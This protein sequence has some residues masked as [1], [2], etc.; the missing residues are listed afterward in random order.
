MDRYICIHGHFYQPPRE[1]PWLEAIEIQDSAFPYHD[2]NERIAAECYAAN[3]VSRI[4]DTEG[5]IAQLV[6]NYASISFNF[7]PTVL[8]WMQQYATDAYEAILEG[9][10]QS[11]EKFSGHGNALAQAYNHMIMPLANSRDKNTQIIWGI[12]DFQFRFG[13]KPEGLWLPETAV[14]LETL[15]LMAQHGID[16]AILAPSQASRVR[17]IDGTEWQDVSGGR[18]YPAMAYRVSLP[19]GRVMA[20]FFYDGPIAQALAFEGLLDNGEVFAN[21]LLS[22]FAD[23][24][25]RL[26]HIATDGESYGHHHRGG[27]MALAHA[28]HHIESN[29]LAQV[30]NY[31]RYLDHHPPTYEV[32]IFEN[33]SWSCVHGIERWRSDCGCNSGGHSGWN[34]G[35]RAPLRAALDWLR[36]AVNPA[37]ERLAGQFL[38]DPWAAR[39]DYIDII[40]DRSPDRISAFL[41]RHATR[42]L[43]SGDEITVLKLLELQRNAMLMYTSCG[44][45]FD[46]LSGI[47]TVQIIQYAGR[48]LQLADQLFGDSFEPGFLERLELAG[49]NIPEHRDGRTI[50]EK[51]VRPAMLDMKDVG[52]HYAL[53][54][55]F[56]DIGERSSIYAYSATRE[57]YRSFQVGGSRL[58]IG[59]AT[60]T[61]EITRISSSLCFGVLHLG[62]HNIACGTGEYHGAQ[63]YEAL[64]KEIS[65]AF[66]GADFPKTI[67]LLGKYFG[68]STYSL[69]S[70]FAD[71]RRK[72][73]NIIME[74]TLREA[75][76][77]YSSIYEHHAPL[78]RFLNG[79]GTP[80]PQ[81]LSVAA[82][83]CLN[84]KLR[85]VLQGD[86]LD[87]D[88]VRP[89]LEEARLAGA[90]LDA[91]ALGLLLAV[92]I[93]S[94]AEQLF[95]QPDDL[96][97]LERLNKAA[98]LVRTLPFE[99][100]L[101]KTQNICYKIL[102]THCPNLEEKVSLGD[103]NA[104]EWL[105]HYT[106]LA[107]NFM[108]RTPLCPLN[109]KPANG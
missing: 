99:V 10:R 21:R 7:G 66:A 93:E 64:T 40:V 108:L 83:L 71:E 90:T 89:L 20:L 43:S 30:T 47:E 27:D 29:G 39:D 68:T 63:K 35:W 6:N 103:Q 76:A 57:D 84:A 36:D 55:L 3:A 70:L 60:V 32:E 23:D 59:R 96:S 56:Q 44:W 22:A 102:H 86:G 16:F 50:Y 54:S 31:G 91:T 94:L 15:D 97:R 38:T 52:A 74:P 53:S 62:D 51:Y 95:D 73:L 75:E 65:A 109:S 1:S 79:S 69:T 41:N 13:R 26:V 49:S 5:R 107:E 19:S 2:W 61:S 67:L 34:Q 104:Q 8:L 78:I 87:P 85:K 11:L 4:W 100:N 37:F 14:D 58:V 105:R 80:R 92:N 28:L 106:V 18:I 77:A 12:K 101:W 45:F 24:S 82:D 33:S 42:P 88:V 48:V 81:L 98:Q 9:D 46:E 25:P 72:V 17:P